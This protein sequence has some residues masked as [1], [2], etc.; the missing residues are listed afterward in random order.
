MIAQLN[1][2]SA[3]CRSLC[4]IIKNYTGKKRRVYLSRFV[5][6]NHPN[7]EPYLDRENKYLNSDHSIRHYHYEEVNGISLEAMENW[8][9]EAIS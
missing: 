9:E 5:F 7:P 4:D 1:A 3:W 2:G 8:S 6:S